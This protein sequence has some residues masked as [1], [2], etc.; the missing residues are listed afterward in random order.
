VGALLFRAAQESIRNIT[1]HAE[2]EHVRVRLERAGNN[3]ILEITDDG[4]GFAQARAE[5]AR[6]EG[7]LGLRLLADLAHDN[8]ATLNLA[9]TPGEGTTVLVEVPLG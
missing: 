3:A 8:G 4:R 2:A 9:S 7:H 6:T 5:A 1:A